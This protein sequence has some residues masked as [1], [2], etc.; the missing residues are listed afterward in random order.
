MTENL[1][2]WFGFIVGLAMAS[3]GWLLVCC[4]LVHGDINVPTAIRGTFRLRYLARE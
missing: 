4:S 3:C 1:V 2:Q